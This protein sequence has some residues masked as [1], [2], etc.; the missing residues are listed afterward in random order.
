VAGFVPSRTDA[1]EEYVSNDPIMEAFAQQMSDSN[2]W[3][4][5][6]EYSA[7]TRIIKAAIQDV[8]SGKLSLEDGLKRA[9]QELE[10]HL[11]EKGYSW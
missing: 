2:P 3:V 4:E 6:P 5:H 9:Q 8:L 7:F 11:K 1:A 10:A